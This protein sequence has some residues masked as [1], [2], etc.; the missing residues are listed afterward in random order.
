M[1]DIYGGDYDVQYT[2]LYPDF[3][4]GSDSND[5]WQNFNTKAV[6][7][8]DEYASFCDKWHLQQAYSDQQKRYLVVAQVTPSA[9]SVEA[10]LAGVE[11][12]GDA[13][14]LYVADDSYRVTAGMY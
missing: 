7:D 2:D 4:D 13:A 9:L 5:E 1:H 6:M 11:Y 10:M 12:D 8:Y 3:D 14:R